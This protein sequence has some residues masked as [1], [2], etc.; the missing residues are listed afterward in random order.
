MWQIL[1]PIYMSIWVISL[2]AQTQFKITLEVV[3][4]HSPLSHICWKDSY[5]D[6]VMRI[7]YELFSQGQK[8][9]WPYQIQELIYHFTIDISNILEKIIPRCHCLTV[10]SLLTIKK[11]E[12]CNSIP[13]KNQKYV[14]VNMYIYLCLSVE[15]SFIIYQSIWRYSF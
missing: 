5:Q 10:E 4:Y 6:F 7:P 11:E 2:S 1:L 13:L 9:P 8:P 14:D 15:L 12:E 3:R